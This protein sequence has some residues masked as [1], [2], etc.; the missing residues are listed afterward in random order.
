MN[1]KNNE[2]G[3]KI[4]SERNLTFNKEYILNE[5]SKISSI[6][7]DEFS[8]IIYQNY[9]TRNHPYYQ[10]LNN[11]LTNGKYSSALEHYNVSFILTNI[12]K[13]S[14]IIMNNQKMYALTEKDFI[15]NSNSFISPFYKKWL[16]IFQTLGIKET[17]AKHY[18]EYMLSVFD[19]IGNS[20]YTM[21]LR[22]INIFLR[23]IEVLFNYYSILNNKKNDFEIAFFS[24][25]LDLYSVLKIFDIGFQKNQYQKIQLFSEKEPS[26][27]I[28][29]DMYIYTSFISALAISHL[30]KHKNISYSF[31]FDP[32]N[33]NYYIPKIV[34]ENGLQNE[35]I[36]DLNLIKYPN[37]IIFEVK[38]Q[39][40]IYDFMEKYSII[41][42]KETSPEIKENIN[43]VRTGLIDFLKSN[44]C[45][46]NIIYTLSTDPNKY[47]QTQFFKLFYE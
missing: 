34:Q 3:I 2:L 25:L 38:E 4:L 31:N 10:N 30:Q 5:L 26:D 19:R 45:S 7:F 1:N 21:N 35:W 33:I 46:D 39:G 18:A 27:G 22:E 40:N 9:R 43:T 23:N 47:S 29:G 6:C 28:L 15:V 32:D 41:N 11:V 12:S 16:Y 36:N 24:E 14:S 20:Y 42:I 44:N 8:E 13:I 37:A 17:D